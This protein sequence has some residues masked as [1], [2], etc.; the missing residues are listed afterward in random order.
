MHTTMSNSAHR[1]IKEIRIGS[2]VSALCGSVGVELIEMSV[3]EDCS[4]EVDSTVAE[5]QN[6]PCV[7]L[8]NVTTRTSVR[9]FL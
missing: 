7:F 6:D 3:V 2:N 8:L 4:V 5:T 1:V 9:Y